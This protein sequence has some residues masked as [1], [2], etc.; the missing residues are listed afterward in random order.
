MSAQD[1]K[2]LKLLKDYAD[3]MSSYTILL[4]PKTTLKVRVPR[5]D[6]LT[7]SNSTELPR[8]FNDWIALFG[9]NRIIF[10]DKT[11]VFLTFSGESHVSSAIIKIQDRTNYTVF[12][13]PPS[14]EVTL[15]QNRSFQTSHYIRIC[16]PAWLS[17]PARSL[18]L[19]R[20]ALASWTCKSGDLLACFPDETLA[21][22]I[23]ELLSRKTNWYCEMVAEPCAL[24]C[25]NCRSEMKFEVR[26]ESGKDSESVV[27]SEMSMGSDD[28][29]ETDDGP[30]CFDKTGNE[31]VILST[32]NSKK[33]YWADDEVN[34]VD[35]PFLNDLDQDKLREDTASD[36]STTIGT[37]DK[38]KE[39]IVT[40]PKFSKDNIKQNEP[41]Q[42]ENRSPEKTINV[43]SKGTAFG[44]PVD[45]VKVCETKEI[46]TYP[47][48]KRQSTNQNQPV[49]VLV[50]NESIPN[51]EAK[52]VPPPKKNTV[53]NKSV[54]H[55]PQPPKKFN[56]N[57]SATTQDLKN[58]SNRGKKSKSKYVPPPLP[59]YDIEIP[60]RYFADE[61]DDNSP[62]P[63]YEMKPQPYSALPDKS[64]NRGESENRDKSNIDSA[65]RNL[66][67]SNG[68]NK[69]IS[70]NTTGNSN[71]AKSLW[72]KSDESR[73][74]ARSVKVNNFSNEAD[75]QWERPKL[76]GSQ[77]SN[78]EK[79]SYPNSE[80]DFGYEFERPS[81]SGQSGKDISMPINQ[82]Q[83]KRLVD[84]YNVSRRSFSPPSQSQNH[85]QFQHPDY[86]SPEY[87]LQPS[88]RPY[89]D[90]DRFKK[91]EEQGFEME[92]RKLNP[93]RGFYD[94]DYI[95]RREEE[96][97]FRRK[98][99][100]MRRYYE[101]KMFREYEY[102][103]RRKF[104]EWEERRRYEEFEGRRRMDDFDRP[105][106]PSPPRDYGMRSSD[107][108][109]RGE[110]SYFRD[111]YQSYRREEERRKFEGLG[112]DDERRKT[113]T[114]DKE[115]DRNGKIVAPNFT[116]VNPLTSVRENEHYNL[117]AS[118]KD[119]LDRRDFQK[120]K[121]EKLKQQR[122]HEKPTL[123]QHHPPQY[124]EF[125][126]HAN[127]NDSVIAAHSD[128]VS[129]Y[130]GHSNLGNMAD[131]EEFDG[132][133][134]RIDEYDFGEADIPVPSVLGDFDSIDSDRKT[135]EEVSPET[136]EEDLLI[137]PPSIPRY[138][139]WPDEDEHPK[140]ALSFWEKNGLE[141]KLDDSTQVYGKKR[142]QKL[143]ERQ[144]RWGKNA[145]SA[146]AKNE[147]NASKSNTFVR[148]SAPAP[149][150]A[151][152]PAK[153]F[154]IL[155]TP[156]A[157]EETKAKTDL[158]KSESGSDTLNNSNLTPVDSDVQNARLV[159]ILEEKQRR[160]EELEALVSSAPDSMY[161]YE[162]IEDE[163][164][165]GRPK[166]SD[167]EG[168]FMILQEINCSKST[169]KKKKK[170]KSKNS[171]EP[172]DPWPELVKSASVAPQY[173]SEPE[174]P[175]KKVNKIL[176]LRNGAALPSS[177]YSELKPTTKANSGKHVPY[178]AP[179]S[180]FA[181]NKKG[182]SESNAWTRPPNIVV[183]E[184]KPTP[185]KQYIQP[186]TSGKVFGKKVD[187]WE[188]FNDQ[189]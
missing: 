17:E 185:V 141:N 6:T 75:K 52:Y 99:L 26:D 107:R 67:N 114:Y 113:D 76:R 91:M 77:P 188:F 59:Q 144:G 18:L 133:G 166:F 179:V 44:P 27:P 184:P 10:Y 2:S 131:F 71:A 45:W 152:P 34:F 46:N 96:E 118:K 100:E 70:S 53:T 86:R 88:P 98:E 50:R 159:A 189:L 146:K 155:E 163:R 66:N 148:A 92:F 132:P 145:I 28:V 134:S 157:S 143:M 81:S 130:D 14:T 168:P 36:I 31:V 42:I 112:I 171:D 137:N 41:A 49:S 187:E 61:C 68:W 39:F 108:M 174:N 136:S 22:T 180:N 116:N 102:E 37:S 89:D 128:H 176:V 4:D 129:N 186:P 120:T 74:T 109:Y 11:T 117:I 69:Q 25:E 79:R 30:V 85:Q 158:S 48:V 105:R 115:R 19:S 126:N 62:A 73:P 43:E 8:V 138:K 38:Q 167:S 83:P 139:D 172:S 169:V 16:I 95:K 58:N 177:V 72:E 84:D 111:D 15:Y 29:I 142:M 13:E 21:S 173:G 87:S 123:T 161:S 170:S 121:L 150:P 122:V 125:N 32:S 9:L 124:H 33:K 90:Y 47:V 64:P 164:W 55:A 165:P 3:N 162:P 60:R 147:L 101:E 181:F 154:V 183:D 5:W 94:E 119:S 135:I 40:T 93:S 104:E 182:G 54:A 63:N 78:S 110:S 57:R 106:M 20:N 178:P 103:Q 151:T 35:F 65:N 140:R 175:P 160:I 127:G 51:R 156:R 149:A 80:K 24:Y 23:V 153:P 1:S 12:A 7:T 56:Q 82:Q 97:Y